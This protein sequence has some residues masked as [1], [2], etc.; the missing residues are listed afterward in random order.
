[1]S[2]LVQVSGDL[3]GHVEVSRMR[4]EPLF[5]DVLD[6]VAL[7]SAVSVARMFIADTLRRWHVLFIEDHPITLRMLGYQRHIVFEVA[8]AHDKALDSPSTSWICRLMMSARWCGSRRTPHTPRS[9]RVSD[10]SDGGAQQDSQAEHCGA[11]RALG[12]ALHA[13]QS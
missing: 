13:N 6:L 5:A 3:P 7:P 10:S 9:L 11:G 4:E 12:A 2:A 1:M 8:D